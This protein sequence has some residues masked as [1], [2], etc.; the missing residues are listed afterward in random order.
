MQSRTMNADMFAGETESHFRAWV[1]FEGIFLIVLGIDALV[2][3]RTSPMGSA[4]VFGWL[5]ALAGMMQI[6]HAFQ[7]RD[8]SRFFVSLL[9]GIFR[10]TLGTLLMMY[11]GSSTLALT[12]VL[13]FYFIA[14]GLYRMLIALSIHYPSWGW[15]V[16]SGAVAVVLGMMLAIG[17][18][19]TA[20]WF[21]GFAIGIDLIV[22]GCALLMLAGAVHQLF[23]HGR[24]SA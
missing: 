8:R 24:V 18:P 13:S 15:A 21:I 10:G 19:T 11:P 23:R 20:L 16:A 9:D 12:L 2:Y 1:M 17:W 14:S 7:I 22:S 5:L 3:Y 4:F 6:A